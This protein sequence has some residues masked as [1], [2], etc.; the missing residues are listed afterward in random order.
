MGKYVV[1]TISLTPETKGKIT[2]LLLGG[3]SYDKGLERLIEE[4]KL[5]R[6]RKK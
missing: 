2:E 1:T 6:K 4:L 5:C 3:E